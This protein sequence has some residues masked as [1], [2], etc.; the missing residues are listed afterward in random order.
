MSLSLRALKRWLSAFNIF[1]A[2][3]SE[4]QVTD[5]GPKFFALLQPNQ[6]NGF[7]VTNIFVSSG[8]QPLNNIPGMPSIGNFGLKR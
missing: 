3:Y 4:K 8:N 7:T 2:T 5:T 1:V 6:V